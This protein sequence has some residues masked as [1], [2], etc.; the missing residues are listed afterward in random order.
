MELK[1]YCYSCAQP[2]AVEDT[3]AG[4]EVHCPTCRTQLR[5]PTVPGLVP[6]AAR[7]VVA[8]YSPRSE[9]VPVGERP[10]RW[11]SWLQPL[12]DRPGQPLRRPLGVGVLGGLAVFA[13][14]CG[15]LAMLTT[16]RTLSWS[17]P[18]ATAPEDVAITFG[19]L[20]L[21]MGT[22][23][24]GL[25]RGWNWARLVLAGTLIFAAITDPFI[26]ATGALGPADQGAL[27]FGVC[28][29]GVGRLY[30]AVYLL[31]PR[32]SA[33]CKEMRD[34]RAIHRVAA[35]PRAET[36]GVHWTHPPFAQPRAGR[37]QH[38]SARCPWS[39]VVVA[40][41]GVQ[42]G[43]YTPAQ[44]IEFYKTGALD[45]AD[46]AWD[47]VSSQWL[48]L[49]LFL[50]SLPAVFAN[51]SAHEP[52]AEESDDTNGMGIPAFEL[53]ARKELGFG[54]LVPAT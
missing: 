51:D 6:S 47:P 45:A 14:V 44:L 42:C 13:G 37:L 39:Q 26:L 36:P 28:L 43:P 32:V 20:G 11:P 46:F 7:P 12:E 8:Q 52:K 49:I 10:S 34:R 3:W 48:P 17:G 53:P 19:L 54:R 50:D 38:V 33:Y 24:V 29:L 31:S 2:I 16:P 40:K 41:G 4:L 30:L 9:P 23:G 21:L 25:L 22:L 15:I 35:T 27:L 5:I 1:F 18:H